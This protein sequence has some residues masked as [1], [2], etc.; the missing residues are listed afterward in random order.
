MKNTLKIILK[1]ILNHSATPY[2]CIVLA[3]VVQFFT[4]WDWDTNWIHLVELVLAAVAM[5]TAVRTVAKVNVRRVIS[6]L[7]AVFMLISGISLCDGENW[8]QPTGSASAVA[9]ARLRQLMA[10]DSSNGGNGSSGHDGDHERDSFDDLWMSEKTC[11]YCSGTGNCH[12]CGGRGYD[13]CSS[14]WSTGKCTSCNGTGNDTGY[15]D[16]IVC[17]GRGVCRTCDGKG[18]NT[19]TWCSGTGRCDHCHGKGTK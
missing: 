14:C 4:E 6:A 13:Q 18:K 10:Q 12:L 16:C 8:K 2:A 11:V 9:E 17:Y 5:Y 7:S 3:A 19:C 15:G 1:N